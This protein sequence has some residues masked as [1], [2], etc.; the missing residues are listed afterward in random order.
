MYNI[1]YICIILYIY[2]YNIIYICMYVCNLYRSSNYVFSVL[3]Y[4]CHKKR[5]THT[6]VRVDLSSC[7]LCIR[8]TH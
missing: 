1:I 5:K 6:R 4:T 2:V 8:H 3:V 7:I